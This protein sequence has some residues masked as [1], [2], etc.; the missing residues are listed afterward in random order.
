ML[1]CCLL[2]YHICRRL[3][4]QQNRRST[5]PK[6]EHNPSSKFTNG[7][8]MQGWETGK[9]WK[10]LTKGHAQHYW[11]KW[12]VNKNEKTNSYFLHIFERTGSQHD[13]TVITQND[14]LQCNHK[15]NEVCELLCNNFKG[16]RPHELQTEHDLDKKWLQ[17]IWTWPFLCNKK[18]P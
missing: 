9:S 13:E 3:Y 7:V 11:M 8:W 2:S 17:Q 12:Q 5:K 6:L 18:R 14:I 1:C 10:I 15:K 16:C 4:S